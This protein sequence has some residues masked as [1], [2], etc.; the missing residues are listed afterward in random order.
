MVGYVSLILKNKR[1]KVNKQKVEKKSRYFESL[2]SPNFNDSRKEE[3]IINYNICLHTLKNFIE[4]VHDDSCADI[5]HNRLK[6]SMEKFANR[7]FA[8]LLNLLELSVL[9]L[10]DELT[11][12]IVDVIALNW[13]LP[14]KVIDVWLLAEELNVKVLRDICMSV[15]LDRFTE[16]PT[17]S[18]VRLSKDQFTRL[19]NNVN[20]SIPAIDTNCVTDKWSKYNNLTLDVVRSQKK[21]K[22]LHGSVVYRIGNQQRCKENTDKTAYVYIWNDS[23]QKFINVPE[24][25]KH[26]VGMQFIAKGF[27]IYL[28]GGE[29]GFGTGKFNQIILRYCLI[30]KKWYY[31]ATLPSPRRHMIAAFLGNNLVL[32]GGVGKYRLQLKSVD[33]LDIQT[34]RWEDGERILETFINVPPHCV[35]NGALFFLKSALYVYFFTNDGSQSHLLS[36]PMNFSNSSVLLM[37]ETTLLVDAINHSGETTLSRITVESACEQENC[38]VNNVE[39]RPIPY[40]DQLEEIREISITL[41]S[42]NTRYN[43]CVRS[44]RLILDGLSSN[45][46][47]IVPRDEDLC[48]HIHTEAKKINEPLA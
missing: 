12:D 47:T 1:F 46:T 43:L 34:G 16:L 22:R 6:V 7:R 14:G 27:S 28:V 13:L 2:L 23:G 24:F 8:E 45:M 10:A 9:F 48:L 5:C 17:E 44:A 25:V 4:W 33:I 36:I 32:V 15:C 19:I 11:C 39:H 29:T 37:R 40:D 30:S 42:T 18:V 38:S 35:A 3:H 21:R 31:Q 41:N 26:L 20:K